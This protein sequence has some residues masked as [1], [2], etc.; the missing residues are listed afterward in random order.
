MADSFS[1]GALYNRDT[2]WEPSSGSWCY[3]FLRHDNQSWRWNGD[4]SCQ[5]CGILE[6][7]ANISNKFIGAVIA[8]SVTCQVIEKGQHPST[9]SENRLLISRNDVEWRSRLNT[10]TQRKGPGIE[11]CEICPKK[12]REVELK[13]KE[14]RMLMGVR[15]KRPIIFNAVMRSMQI[16]VENELVEAVESRHDSVVLAVRLVRPATRRQP[17]SRHK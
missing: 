14:S 4:R 13:L 10:Q 1:F 16:W 17:G 3:Y 12:R 2:G 5:Y 11:D 7:Q 6:Y 9:L 8:R 15:G